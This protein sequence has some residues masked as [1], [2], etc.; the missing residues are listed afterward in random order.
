MLTD[1]E[2]AQKNQMMPITEVAK[3][4]GIEE[5]GLDLYGKYKAKITMAEL[6]KHFLHPEELL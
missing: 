4:I 3:K 2:I 5:S 1:I 6:R